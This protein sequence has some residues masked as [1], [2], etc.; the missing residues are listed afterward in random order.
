MKQSAHELWQELLSDTEITDRTREQMI[1]QA[2]GLLFPKMEQRTYIWKQHYN[3][4]NNWYDEFNNLCRA[5][6]SEKYL[7]GIGYCHNCLLEDLI[8]NEG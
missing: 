4:V 6:G 8:P 3:M 1:L 2:I 7:I 5:C